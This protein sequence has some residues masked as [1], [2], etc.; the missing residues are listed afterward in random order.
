M[1]TPDLELQ[2]REAMQ[3]LF[4][5]TQASPL[6]LPDHRPL[7]AQRLVTVGAVVV[8]VAGVGVAGAWLSSRTASPRVVEGPGGASVSS[9]PSPSEHSDWTERCLPPNNT[10]ASEFVG[11]TMADAIAIAKAQG[12]HLRIYG[13]A[14]KCLDQIA[15]LPT[16]EVDVTVDQIGADNAIPDTARILSAQHG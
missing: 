1:S 8:I 15:N 3:R 12:I 16:N 13:A 5:E 11:L 6:R 9:S 10:P 14:G 2:V 7:R 4:P